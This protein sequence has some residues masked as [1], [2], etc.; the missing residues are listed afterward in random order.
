MDLTPWFSAQAGV[1]G[2][3]STWL[4]RSIFVSDDS[5]KI[6]NTA[7]A[8]PRPESLE[9]KVE[10]PSVRKDST[11]TTMTPR[12]RKPTRAQKTKG[13]LGVG[14]I[15]DKYR[16]EGVIGT[17]GFAVVY[18]ATH[19]LLRMPVA[20]K[21]LKPDVVREH[22]RLI[23]VLCD[24]AGFLAQLNHPN[25][26]R[27]Y[28]VTHRDEL[29]Y[30]VMECIEG[31]SLAEA[32][33]RGRKLS[34]SKVL[35][36]GI[37][38]ARGLRAAGERGIIHRD[39]KPANILLS[40]GG[41]PKLVDFGL[42][43]PLELAGRAAVRGRGTAGT[44]AYMAPEVRTHPTSVDA[45]ADIYSLGV[46]LFQALTGS[47]PFRAND[48][49]GYA[50]LHLNAPP[51]DPRSL[52]DSMPDGLADLVLSMLAKRPEDRPASYD[53]LIEK[54]RACKALLALQRAR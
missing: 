37:D 30:I 17:G 1:E 23:K 48:P 39:I 43:L 19:L 29:T 10:D 50:E 34:V 11:R 46:T 32:L 35:S 28:D 53:V 47:L 4:P 18:G 36:L 24:E 21:I 3:L 20:L 6:L 7:V 45:R 5:R 31:R 15:L 9:R 16:I 38:V 14:S 44:P 41:P 52:V 54:L 8:L 27:I 49:A 26:V 13:L 40:Q 25:I 33:S 22:P 2:A 12:R 51:P 42:A